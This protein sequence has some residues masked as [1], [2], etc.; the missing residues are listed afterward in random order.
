MVEIEICGEPLRINIY[1]LSCKIIACEIDL[2]VQCSK[3]FDGCNK[4]PGNI[5]TQI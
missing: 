5:S 2:A 3:T 4:T 1:K